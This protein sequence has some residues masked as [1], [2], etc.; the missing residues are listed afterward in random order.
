MDAKLN[1]DEIFA[2]QSLD[3]DAPRGAANYR[4]GDLPQR[5]FA[6]NL[7]TR[8]PGGTVVLTKAGERALFRHACLCALLAIERGG[9]SDHSSGVTNWLL[10][11]GFIEESHTRATRHAITR[12][13]QLW[14]ASCTDDRVVVAPQPTAADFALRRA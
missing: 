6:Y 3:P 2:L 13:G 10:S 8:R 9:L 1:S 12:R 11:S 7:A 14:L 5:L 4:E